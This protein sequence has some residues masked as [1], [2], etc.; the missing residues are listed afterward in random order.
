MRSAGLRLGGPRFFGAR[1]WRGA[2]FWGRGSFSLPPWKEPQ[3][4]EAPSALPGSAGFPARILY[5]RGRSRHRKLIFVHRVVRI[6]QRGSSAAVAGCCRVDQLEPTSGAARQP[7][8][9]SFTLVRRALHGVPF[10]AGLISFAVAV[11]VVAGLVRLEARA[12]LP[13]RASARASAAAASINTDRVIQYI[14]ERFGIP[15]TVKLQ[16]GPLES[17]PVLPGYYQAIVAVDYGQQNQAQNTKQSVLVSKDDHYL[18]VGSAVALKAPNSKPEISQHVRELFKVPENMQLAVG[19]PH[20]SSFP[21]FSQV[22]V[23][24]DDGK[25]KQNMDL[26]LAQ[27]GRVLVLGQIYALGIDPRREAL[28]TI[29]LQDQP[30]VGPAN[31]PV[32]IVEYAD[33]ECP[34]C[35]QL[36]DFVE[37]NL[38]PKYG[39]K[40]HFVFKEFPLPMHD[41]SMQAAIANECAY[42][43]DPSTFVNYRTLIFAR[44]SSFT[45]NNVRD[46]LLQYGQEA[47]IDR[48]KLSACIDAKASL[49]RIDADKR[50]ADKL[51]VNRTPTSFVNGKLV[52][53]LPPADEFYK[54]VDAALAERAEKPERRVQA[55]R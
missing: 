22:Q 35:A 19:A 42:Q 52:V 40:I 41:W 7:P 8:E 2:R 24:V 50:E 39:D 49:R 10:L 54:I 55:R 27:G 31:A 28:R 5:S 15:D 51:G 53:G 21:A 12:P 38:L 13:P 32:T 14:R 23:T 47:G 26:Y 16:V 30:G 25:K 3:T 29:S 48:L 33:L 9:R 11:W 34:T 20:S 1:W 45:V 36:H 17:S 37:K 18:V 43:L 44:Q 4:A 6:N 46:L